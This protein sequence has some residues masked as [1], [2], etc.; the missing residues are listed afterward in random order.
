VANDEAQDKPAEGQRDHLMDCLRYLAVV[1]PEY[2]K[3]EPGK[4]TQSPAYAA[5]QEWQKGEKQGGDE[6]FMGAGSIPQGAY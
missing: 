5:F 1:N 4:L 3:P 6:I 2:V